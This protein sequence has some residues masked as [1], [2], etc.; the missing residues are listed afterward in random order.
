MNKRK[1]YENEFKT[2]RTRAPVNFRGTMGGFELLR[3]GAVEGGGQKST[4]RQARGIT[5][6]SW[7]PTVL[8]FDLQSF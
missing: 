5:M 3:R 2:I 7:T 4:N 8:R 6:D 1:T